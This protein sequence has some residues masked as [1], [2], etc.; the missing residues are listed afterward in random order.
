M[1]KR[2]LLSLSAGLL[3]TVGF[4]P[5]NLWFCVFFALVPFLIA[6]NKSNTFKSHAILGFLVCFLPLASTLYPLTSAGV[7][8]G[9]VDFSEVNYSQYVNSQTI[10]LHTLWLV[11]SIYGGLL[12]ALFAIA[13][14][15]GRRIKPSLFY[16]LYVPSCWIIIVE[17][18]RNMTSWG[19]NWAPLSSV[20]TELL[21]V[22]QVLSIGGSSLG[23]Y[24]ILLTNG[25]IYLAIFQN[26]LPYRKT[27]VLAYS[28]CFI[29]LF[30]WGQERLTGIDERTD[31]AAFKVAIIQFS[32]AL[33]GE[34]PLTE[35]AMD[36]N[37][38]NLSQ[39]VFKEHGNSID[40]VV[41]PE[42][43]GF[44]SMSRDNTKS[45]QS[46]EKTVSKLADWGLAMKKVID[47]N[48]ALLV[49]GSDTVKQ[50]K[51]HNSLIVFNRDGP[52]YTYDKKL[53]VPF[54][55]EQPG[56]LSN[57]GAKG[58]SSYY[59]GESSGIMLSNR[60]NIGFFICQEVLYSSVVRGLV[61]G[62]AD[63]LITI[64]NDGVFKNS[65]AAK[66][67]HKATQMRAI[68]SGRYIVRAMKS[69][70]SSVIKPSGVV[71]SSSNVGQNTVLFSKA[72]KNSDRNIYMQTYSVWNFLW[73]A[74]WVLTLILTRFFAK[75]SG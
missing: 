37:Y 51:D 33:S 15:F 65:I 74:I 5:F 54:A 68:E 72:Y 69:G 62:N 28:L 12:G 14:K 41:L 19:Y 71:R 9:W 50:E 46:S 64:G 63:L 34:K 48:P 67:N 75:K 10:V 4:E 45:K 29:G 16:L 22:A 13:I 73:I 30:L 25:V 43:V 61:Q 7:W 40:L 3:L 18:F 31:N 36:I 58:K 21:P 17:Q 8:T 11:L 2:I 24:L 38:Y 49:L 56:W 59:P 26:N 23:T 20:L 42:S 52:V 1:I 44:G 53:L 32:E 27:I 55:E 60:A 57:F 70:I 39:Q 66:L 35:F 6:I 47:N